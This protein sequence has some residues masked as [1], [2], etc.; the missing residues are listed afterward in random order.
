MNSVD[1]IMLVVALILGISLYKLLHNEKGITVTIVN[2]QPS[3]KITNI[4]N[5]KETITN[6]ENIKQ[7]INKEINEKISEIVKL[8]KNFNVVNFTNDIKALFQNL[9]KSF[10]R[11]NL[12][13]VENILSKNMF[14][15]LNDEINNFNNKETINT[16]LIRIKSINIKNINIK[17]KKASIF[18]EL[19]SEQ[20]TL[21]KDSAGKTIKGDDNKI[22]TIKDLWYVTKDFSKKQSNWILDKTIGEKV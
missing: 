5:K 9:L 10:N 11:K 1:I 8:D 17:G 20:I 3:D 6:S 18:I 13:S 22:M 12:K 15:I 14:K 19:L 2:K 16:E 7:D 21:I 4:N